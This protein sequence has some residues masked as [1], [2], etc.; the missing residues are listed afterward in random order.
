MSKFDIF[1]PRTCIRL[2]TVHFKNW[3]GGLRRSFWLRR[4]AMR[5]AH[6]HWF[7]WPFIDLENEWTGHSRRLRDN[8]ENL[9][10]LPRGIDIYRIVT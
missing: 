9:Q 3:E 6:E 8:P 10:P 4:N 1:D 2:W 5:H 7:S